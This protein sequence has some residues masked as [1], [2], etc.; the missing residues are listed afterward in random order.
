MVVMVVVVLTAVLAV[1]MCDA[2]ILAFVVCSLA[3]EFHLLT[4]L[5]L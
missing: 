3:Y 1:V 2:T 4:W 5:R